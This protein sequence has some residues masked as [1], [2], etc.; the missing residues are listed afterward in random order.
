MKISNFAKWLDREFYP[1]V[2]DSWDNTLFR[3]RVLRV[4]KPTDRVLDVGAG[5]GILPQMNFR[6]LA[7]D[8]QGV[9]LN[10]RVTSN[11]NL[12]AG[13]I[14]N[15]A[16]TPF[17][18]TTFDLVIS[19]NVVEHL[20]DPDAVFREVHR[21][22][23]SGGLFLFKTPNVT[24]YM[25]TIS[26]LTPTSFHKFYNHLRG[27]SSEDTFPTVYRANSKSAVL[28][29]AQRTGFVIEYI[30]RIES[31]PEYLRILWPAYLVGILYERIVNNVPGLEPFRILLVA[32]LRKP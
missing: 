28:A 5:A 23:K 8:V 6:E 20:A 31:R 32:G 29:L 15:A 26:R 4:L 22:L 13:H 10:P 3:Q 19:D 21:V 2:E 30:E 7:A 1:G 27:R 11:P 24:H 12:H 25:A 9:D 14:A 17:A 18:D 16:T